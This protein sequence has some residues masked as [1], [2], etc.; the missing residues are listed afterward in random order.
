[1]IAIDESR[2]YCRR[3]LSAFDA[4]SGK[5]P[6]DPYKWVPNGN[7]QELIK[8]WDDKDSLYYWQGW[9]KWFRWGTRHKTAA[10][11]AYLGRG[12]Y[13]VLCISSDGEIHLF[14]GYGVYDLS[15]G[16]EEGLPSTQ[17]N[18]AAKTAQ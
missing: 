2:L 4:I 1:V 3:Q 6:F 17:S 16:R 8:L 15:K 13:S 7:N 18:S 10:G 14:D 11:L 5:R 12:E 9:G